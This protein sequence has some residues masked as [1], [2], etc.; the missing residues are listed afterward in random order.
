[1]AKKVIDLDEAQFYSLVENTAR[2]VLQESRMLQENECDEGWFG[3]LLKGVGETAVDQAKKGYNK[4]GA[5]VN[6]LN[7]DE[8]GAKGDQLQAEL[9]GMPQ[10]IKN[11]VAAFR[12]QK[13]AVL[14]KEVAEYAAKLKAEMQKKQGKLDNTRQ[15]QASYQQRSASQ[16]ERYQQLHNKPLQQQ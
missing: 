5:R 13:M 6:Q 11:Q 2:R 16:R 8:Q 14:N 3:N 4:I 12:K 1:M 7:A 10:Q 15:K 9:A